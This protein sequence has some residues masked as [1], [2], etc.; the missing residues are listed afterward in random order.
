M[1]LLLMMDRR[2]RLN[3]TSKLL[4]NGRLDLPHQ[5]TVADSFTDGDLLFL[6]TGSRNQDILKK[7]GDDVRI[8]WGHFILLLKKKTVP[9]LIG[10]GKKLR[11]SFMENKLEAPAT[12]GYDKLALVRSLGETKKSNG[13]LLIG[14]DDIYSIQYFGENLR[15]YWNRTGSE[16]IVSQFRKQ[17]R[18]TKLK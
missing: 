4:L 16:T 17:N 12:N 5:G 7:K 2:I 8:D 9:M 13:H 14:Y 3:S 1:K 10:D 6:R 11:K 15:P 18:N